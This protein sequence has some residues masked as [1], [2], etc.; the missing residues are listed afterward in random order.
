MTKSKMEDKTRNRKQN[1]FMNNTDCTNFV[2]SASW[3]LIVKMTWV[4]RASYSRI[5]IMNFFLEKIIFQV[6]FVYFIRIV[7]TFSTIG[8][9][10]WLG[11]ENE[12]SSFVNTMITQY[13][14]V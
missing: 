10:C 2:R 8:I 5:E 12:V 6:V 3:R 4:M 7:S 13:I 1:S 11:S 14:C 9:G